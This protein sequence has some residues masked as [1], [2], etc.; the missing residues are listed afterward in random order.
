VVET[1]FQKGFAVEV[2]F[3]DTE[4]KFSKYKVF[5]NAYSD[6][7]LQIWWWRNMKLIL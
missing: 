7:P 6:F 2:K 3:Q 4:A 1:S 5:T